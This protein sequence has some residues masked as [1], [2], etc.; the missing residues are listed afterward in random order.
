MNF[1][2]KIELLL[3]G[4]RKNFQSCPDNRAEL[5]HSLVALII[6]LGHGLQKSR[7]RPITKRVKAD[8]LK[9]MGK[10][11]V[12]EVFNSITLAEQSKA[13]NPET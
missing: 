3:Q 1:D 12:N 4:L 2:N 10:S 8:S 9:L 6:F 11:V 13:S 5:C 7:S